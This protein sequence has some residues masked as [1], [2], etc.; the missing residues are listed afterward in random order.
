MILDNSHI[1]FVNLDHR[2]DRL[3]H[4]TSELDRI[5][6]HA[7]RFPG[8]LPA[9]FRE[10][11]YSVMRNRTPGAI[12]CY[13]SQVGIMKQ[14]LELKKHAVVFE[15]DIIFCHDF[16]ERIEYI[17]K[18]TESHE[19]DVIWLGGTFHV[20]AFW[21]K[22]GRSGMNPDC[23]LQIGHDCETTDDIRIVRTFGAFSTFAY[24]VNI[25]SLQKVL[26]LLDDFLPKTIGIDYSFLALGNKIN[27]FAFVPGCT[28]QIDNISDIGTGMTMFSGFAKLNGTIENSRYWY[29][30]LMTDFD[31]STFNFNA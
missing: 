31:P 11:K 20:P 14:A 24:I 7:S 3:D 12:G 16:N 15:D 19:W 25:K 29:Q 17:S 8:L 2:K 13:M 18:W 30:P 27:S 1:A 10:E 4:M 23:S 28:R 6:L 9:Q 21:H 22:K 26:T 5:G